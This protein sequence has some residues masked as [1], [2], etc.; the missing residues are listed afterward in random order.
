MINNLNIKKT[1]KNKFININISKGD[2]YI[3]SNKEIVDKKVIKTYL[4]IL[5]IFI[6]EIIIFFIVCVKK[7][8]IEIPKLKNV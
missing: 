8:A 1:L 6:I 4:S 2:T 3:I 7:E 5:I